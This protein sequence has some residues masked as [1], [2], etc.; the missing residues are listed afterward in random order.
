METPDVHMF[1]EVATASLLALGLVLIVIQ[2]VAREVG[3]RLGRFFAPRHEKQADGIGLI[4]GAMMAL[5]AF[6]LALTL[7]FANAR[8]S[9]RRQGTLAEANAIGTAWL[10][11][12]AIGHPRG[13]AIAHLI[14][15][16]NKARADFVKASIN[17]ET[18]AQAT[19]RTQA[20]QTE[21]WGHM[22]A[23]IREKPDTV[24]VALQAALNDMFD[25]TTA[26]AFAF[27]VKMPPQLFWLLLGLIALAMATLGFQFGVRGT[28]LRTLSFLLICVWTLVV[29]TIL[30]LTA[31]RLG[32][33]RTTTVTY[34]WN[35]QGFGKD[36]AIPA[37]PAPR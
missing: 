25:M 10:R 37:L 8:F 11:A 4:T 28:P 35:A 13:L 34:E 1:V 29:V 32:S 33:F 21:I 14:E 19:A 26:E 5:L 7:S 15:E 18:L 3:Y 12:E 2:V 17:S 23:L 9:E 27:H 36:I 16:Y 20:L 31:T 6:V 24:S 30:D 22:A